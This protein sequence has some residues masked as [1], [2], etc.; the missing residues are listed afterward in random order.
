MNQL[1]RQQETAPE[2]TPVPPRQENLLEEI[3]DIL[4][5]RAP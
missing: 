4:R 1:R 5:A 2:T 3:R